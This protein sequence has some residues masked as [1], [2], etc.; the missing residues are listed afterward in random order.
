M[1]KLLKKLKKRKRASI[2]VEF[3][4]VLPIFVLV[5][6]CAVQ[7]LLYI[8]SQSTIHQ[9]AMDAAKIA[10]AELRG[11]E[12]LITTASPDTQNS[13]KSRIQ[14]KVKKTTATNGV[15]LLYR[16]NNFEHLSENSVPVEFENCKDSIKSAEKMICIYTERK[17]VEGIDQEQIVV[18]IK[19]QFRVIGSLLPAIEQTKVGGTGVSVK[20]L[21][22]RYNYEE[23]EN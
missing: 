14:T 11:H 21:S 19:A 3:L 2:V 20:D 7:I 10:A 12:G 13:L 15:I 9:A 5:I 4:V 17:N 22:G 16:G 23:P 8:L 1:I 6:W 18:K